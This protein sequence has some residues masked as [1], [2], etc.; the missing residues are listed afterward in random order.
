MES[1]EGKGTTFT[2]YFPVTREDVSPE[3][4][5]VSASEYMGKG[6]SI[7]VVDDVKEQREPCLRDAQE[8]ELH[9]YSVS[10][11]E[12]AV[13]YLKQNAVDLVVL[14]MIM[15]PGMDG[16]DTYPKYLKSILIKRRSSSAV[17]LRRNG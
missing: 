5:P 4:V 15:D 8:T 13:E 10:S 9:R 12:E 7:L 11:G 3:Q 16:L 1:E 14:D 2:L 6:E 17:F